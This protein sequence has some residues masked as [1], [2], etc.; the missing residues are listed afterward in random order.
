MR[1]DK[2]TL[3]TNETYRHNGKVNILITHIIL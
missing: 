3:I 2:E 1:I